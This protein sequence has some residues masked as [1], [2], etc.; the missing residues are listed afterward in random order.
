MPSN[1]KRGKAQRAWNPFTWVAGK[2]WGPS[3]DVLIDQI[4]FGEEIKRTK[5]YEQQ[6]KEFVAQMNK[7]KLPKKTTA[8]ELVKEAEAAPSSGR[9]LTPPPGL[10]VT[11]TKSTLG[12]SPTAR[13]FSKEGAHVAKGLGGISIV[14]QGMNGFVIEEIDALGQT[15]PLDSGTI[16][17]S[18]NRIGRFKN[19]N[20]H[21][22]F[23]FINAPSPDSD[24]KTLEQF[25]KY[26]QRI[27]AAINTF[28]HRYPAK[29]YQAADL[30]SR[31]FGGGQFGVRLYQASVF[32]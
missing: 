19:H 29:F 24:V 9:V 25:G 6:A 3:Y 20:P 4:G 5:R 7:I 11:P 12:E 8:V 10:H 31:D 21:R 22:G 13:E 27:R 23:H 32:E 30:A 17:V 2:P 18:P 26:A 28:G 1:K 14:Q 16:Y 15:I